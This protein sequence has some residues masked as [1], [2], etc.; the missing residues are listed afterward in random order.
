[1]SMR[2]GTAAT[3]EYGQYEER[4]QWNVCQFDTFRCLSRR[5]KKTFTDGFSC[6]ILVSMDL[7]LVI[8][9]LREELESIDHVTAALE[10]LAEL[11]ARRS[12]SVTNS[13]AEVEQPRRTRARKPAPPRES[14]ASASSE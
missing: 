5:R 13:D 8:A 14:A 6:L 11:R 2:L 7:K 3:L 12:T 9:Q 1:M 10:R 4:R